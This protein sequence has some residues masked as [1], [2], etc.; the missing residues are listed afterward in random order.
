MKLVF[1]KALGSGRKMAK[2][3]EV[4]KIANKRHSENKG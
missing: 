4:R 2:T 3:K 1:L